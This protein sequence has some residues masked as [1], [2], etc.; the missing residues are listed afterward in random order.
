MFKTRQ[1]FF[2]KIFSAIAFVVIVLTAVYGVA[3][4]RVMQNY[5]EVQIGESKK[6]DQRKNE[7]YM[8]ELERTLQRD[9][10]NLSLILA[11]SGL[12]DGETDI[13]RLREAQAKLSSA[14]RVNQ[15]VYSLYLY[16]PGS[17]Y[18]ITSYNGAYQLDSFLD[19]DWLEI[20]QQLDTNNNSAWMNTRIVHDPKAIQGKTAGNPVLS[21]VY[22]FSSFAVPELKGALVYNINEYHVIERLNAGYRQENETLQVIDHAGI[23]LCH[24]QKLLLGED[25]SGEDCV[26]KILESGE[27]EGYFTSKGERGQKILTSWNKSGFNDWIFVNTTSIEGMDSIQKSYMSGLLFLIVLTLLVGI[28]VAFCLSRYLYS[29]IQQLTAE[30]LQGHTFKGNPQDLAMLKRAVSHMKRE[31]EENQ[32]RQEQTQ[33]QREN[34]C[35][36]SI[37]LYES[38]LEDIPQSLEELLENR[39][40]CVVYFQFQPS[41]QEA[42]QMEAT[43]KLYFFSLLRQLLVQMLPEDYENRE[44]SLGRQGMYVILFARQKDSELPAIAQRYLDYV[45]KRFET[46]LCIGLSDWYQ[47]GP[48]SME[49]LS[50]AAKWSRKAAERVFFAG[51]GNVITEK[52]LPP[53]DVKGDF[54]P[55]QREIEIISALEAGDEDQIRKSVRSFCQSLQETQ[56]ISVD[57]AMLILHQLTG[58]ILKKLS[59]RIDSS[60]E[61]SESSFQIHRIFS[62]QGR[63]L[64]EYEKDLEECLCCQAFVKNQ[65][66]GQELYHQMVS[67]LHEHYQE[68]I[69]AAE[70]AAA[71]NISY[72]YTR[73][74]FKEFSG[75]TPSDY[76]HHLRVR[77]SKKLLGA[78]G[79]PIAE[80]A[81]E[82]GYNNDQSF[83]RAFKRL[84]G[85]SPAAY[86]ASLKK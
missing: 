65:E 26:R 66:G 53:E 23:V 38:F 8:Q 32:K 50:T 45:E 56:D 30:I 18:V 52:E 24:P 17:S 41:D 11:Q 40:L 86:R 25:I 15:M 13:T 82:V 16:L 79:N 37:V 71:L 1:T 64:W 34:H 12:T 3:F 83:V 6:N 10:L 44:I 59:D 2:T 62:L 69:G 54:Y 20:Y 21:F 84:E 77:E 19:Q 58:T 29:P 49:Q 63:L 46:R 36:R 4:S 5:T 85:I 47:G 68:N 35:L 28:L 51:W 73:R 61:L 60:R 80:I 76:I 72:S 27:T 70:L 31:A 9:A 67:Y 39:W 7:E 81:K 75:I 57:A 48:Q 78:C 14:A 55:R 74:I 22:R 42:E 43:E 33:L